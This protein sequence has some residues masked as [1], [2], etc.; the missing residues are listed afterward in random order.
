MVGSGSPLA[1]IATIFRFDTPAS[2]S[3]CPK[4]ANVLVGMMVGGSLLLCYNAL[5]NNNKTQ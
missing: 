1:N 3:K 2:A 5:K 4:K